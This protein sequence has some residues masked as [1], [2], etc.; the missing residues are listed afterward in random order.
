MTLNPAKHCAIG[1]DIGARSSSGTDLLSG[2]AKMCPML[3]PWMALKHRAAGS[4]RNVYVIL[5]KL[6]STFRHQDDVDKMFV[7][8]FDEDWPHV[9]HAVQFGHDF[10]AKRNL[11]HAAIDG[12]KLLSL[13]LMVAQ[14]GLNPG[15]A[16]H[17]GESPIAYA[18]RKRFTEAIGILLAAQADRAVSAATRKTRM[19]P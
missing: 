15:A 2:G 14:G 11:L 8:A 16:V 6:L 1:M 9:R 18:K 13:S 17:D 19:G 10:V 3:S 4:M 12:R 7:R 5:D